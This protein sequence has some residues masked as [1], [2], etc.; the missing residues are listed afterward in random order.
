MVK[1]QGRR[2]EV[3]VELHTDAPDR[4]RTGMRVWALGKNGGRRELTVEDLWPHKSLLVLKFEGVDTISDAVTLVGAELQLPR[5]ERAGLEPGWAYLSDLVG[6]TVFDGEREIGRLVDVAFGAGDAPLL[7]VRDERQKGGA[8]LPYE[9]PFA[10]AYL[11][12]VDVEH[13]QVRM[14]LPEGLL[15]V[16]APVTKEETER[17]G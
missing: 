5:G 9:I 15:D 1:T 13:K 3:G 17:G 2:G 10:E 7:V 8:K 14:R 11:E 4:F 6:C 12:K 16:N